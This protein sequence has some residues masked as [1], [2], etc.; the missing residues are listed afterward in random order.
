MTHPDF[1]WEPAPHTAD[2]A[3]KISASSEVG[4]F[5]AGLAGLLGLL[6]FD[7]EI[8]SGEASETYKF[9]LHGNEIEDLLVDFLTECIYIMEVHSLIPIRIKS[10]QLDENSAEGELETRA[11]RDFE[12]PEVG[13]IKAAT[14]H[15]LEVI[16]IDGKFEAV[17]VFD[18]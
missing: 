8:K 11:V 13:H 2:L 3:I 16:E 7:A 1:S 18:T 6:E 17:I 12:R 9:S 14:Y 4:L 5:H 15:D 10:I